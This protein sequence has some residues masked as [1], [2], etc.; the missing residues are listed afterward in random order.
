M[1]PPYRVIFMGTPAF[2]VPSLQA[3]AERRDLCQVVA[4]VCQP[5]K[6]AGRGRKLAAAPVKVA[7]EA[8]GI[9]THTPVKM[10]SPET[11]AL[12]QAYQPDFMVVAAY[13]RI[14]PPALLAV[15]RLGCI[16]V[17]ASLLP[18]HRGASPIAHVLLDGDAE[19][20]VCIMGMEEGLDTGP[21]FARRALIL[22][23]EDT[24]G[25][26]TIKLAEVGAAL[27]QDSLANIGSGALKPVPQAADGVTYAAL[28]RK[29]DGALDFTQDAA[30][31]ARQ[32][33]AFFPWPGTFALLQDGSRVGVLKAHADPVSPSVS[34]GAAPGSVLQANGRGVQVACAQGSLWLDEVKPEGRKGMPAASWVAGRGVSAGSVFVP[35]S[36][37]ETHPGGS[38][39]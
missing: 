14:L 25:S 39:V 4:V 24:C 35:K 2:A 36:N 20:G 9:P 21:V 16:N 27:L 38:D 26:L 31:L 6:P 29:E 18:R 15:P 33:R 1:Q 13:G 22:A 7:A 19:A 10:K 11:A 28:L 30:R 17:H 37:P 3:L 23:P 5:D 8:M 34:P 12:L 32:V